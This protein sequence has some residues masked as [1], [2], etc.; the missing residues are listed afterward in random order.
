LNPTN[1]AWWTGLP[2]DPLSHAGLSVAVVF[3]L[4]YLLRHAF[5]IFGAPRGRSCEQVNRSPGGEWNIDYRLVIIG[6]LLPDLIDKSLQLWFFPEVF[7]LPGRSI[8]HTLVF[9]LILV[10][11]SLPVLPF[12]RSLGPL[13]FSL[14]SVG[15]L[16]HDRMWESPATLFWPLYGLSYGHAENK[17]SPSWLDWTQSGIGPALLDWAG[18]LVLLIFAVVLHRRRTFLKW[19][20]I[21]VP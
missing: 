8:A 11:F 17:L 16:L 10:V 19:I 12:K 18:A 5:G 21:G 2:T 3:V 1:G 9:N 13:I 15:H 14:A 4:H 6:A 7:N 20:R